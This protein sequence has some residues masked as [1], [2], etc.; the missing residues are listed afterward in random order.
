MVADVNPSKIISIQPQ[1]T[2]DI[3]SIFHE[4]HHTTNV[5]DSSK[6]SKSDK[7]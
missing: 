4:K 6:K 7:L 3:H 1:G 2:M 5:D